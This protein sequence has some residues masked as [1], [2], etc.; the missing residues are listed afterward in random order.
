MGPRQHHFTIPK[1]PDLSLTP[2][3]KTEQFPN[4]FYASGDLLYCK[5][6]QYNINRKSVNMYKDHLCKADTVMSNPN[7]V[8]TE[9]PWSGS[10]TSPSK[11][12]CSGNTYAVRTSLQFPVL[13]FHAPVWS[14]QQP[15]ACVPDVYQDPPSA[16]PSATPPLPVAGRWTALGSCK[17]DTTH[18]RMHVRATFCTIVIKNWNESLQLIFAY[19]STLA[20]GCRRK[21]W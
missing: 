4:Y 11:V 2:K 17:T 10:V 18:W 8:H 15:V 21:N 3:Y 19:L 13:P 16:A 14:P 6:C 20:S 12:L 5:F 7:C 9:Q 1:L